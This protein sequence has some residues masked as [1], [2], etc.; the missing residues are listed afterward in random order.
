MI[1]LFYLVHII[2]CLFL[3]MVVLLQQ[4]KGADLSV[5]GGGA[6]QAAFGARGAAS[7][8]HKLTV[9]GFVGFIFT[10]VS[11]GFMVSSR[12]SS[13][14]MSNL[15]EQTAPAATTTE[16]EAATPLETEAIPTDQ[17]A[18]ST[19]EA[20]DAGVDE[21]EAATEGGTAEADGASEDEVDD[22]TPDR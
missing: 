16:D 7:L 5:F 12:G 2:I 11:I 13:S 14:V 22:S 21:D 15:P 6:T 10:T 3:I 20:G 18:D 17:P 8:L 9:W 1:F 19:G 4:G